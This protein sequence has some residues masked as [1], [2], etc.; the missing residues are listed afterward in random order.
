MS[1]CVGHSYDA[2][3]AAA[4]GAAAT[5]MYSTVTTMR[6]HEGMHR[7]TTSTHTNEAY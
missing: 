6:A 7:Q 3:A 1:I 4:A 5:S 2:T